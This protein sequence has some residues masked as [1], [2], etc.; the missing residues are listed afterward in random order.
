MRVLLFTCGRDAGKARQAT[1]TIPDGWSVAWVVDKPDSGLEVPEGVERIVAPFDRGE[2]LFGKDACLGVAGLLA[3]QAA[4]FGRVAKVDSDCLLIHPSFL[5][6]G[7]LAG[8]RHRSN[9]RAVYGLA[10][11][12]SRPAAERALAGLAGAILK[13]FSLGPESI[14][15]TAR[16]N[17][18]G[19]VLE[20][21]AFWQATHDGSLPPPDKVAIHCGHR[22][23]IPADGPTVENEMVRLGDALGLWRR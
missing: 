11:A 20:V 9:P 4:R 21:G 13:G 19:G 18:G 15:I 12:L 17:A 10:Y 14:E 1:R 3:D 2:T 5:E 22:G 16:S 8:M 23:I 6:V 7:D